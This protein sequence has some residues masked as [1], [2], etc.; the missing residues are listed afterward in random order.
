LKGQL[1]IQYLASFIFFLGLV[2][3]IYFS[4][5]ANLPAFVEEVRKEDV[6]SKAFQL[7]EILI[8]DPGNWTAPVEVKVDVMLIIDVS[9]SMD[10]EAASWG[11]NCKLDCSTFG[12]G[13]CSLNYCSQKNCTDKRCADCDGDGHWADF[14]ESP[15]AI[16][17]AKNASKTFVDQLN[18]TENQD[19]SGIV[20]FNQTD[21][22]KQALVSDKGIVKNSIDQVYANQGANTAIGGGIR[23]ATEHLKNYGRLDAN[24]VQVLL[25]DGRDYPTPSNAEGAAQ[26]AV[27][28]NIKIYTIGLGESGHFNETLLNLIAS[29]TDGKYYHAPSSSDL[30]EIY[31]QIAI[32]MK[33]QPKRIGLSDEKLNKTNLITM[34]K[35]RYLEDLC[36]SFENVQQKLAI[37]EPFSIHIFNISQD[38]GKRNSI[39]ECV[40]PDFPKTIINATIK[41]IVALENTETGQLELAEI[42][43]QM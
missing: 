37:D 27:E 39:M 11:E 35:V 22:L 40:P 8:N 21:Y 38:L 26:E 25:T 7:S 42:I 9:G 14:G 2:I 10:G 17:D 13:L 20:I 29:I 32:E 31:K 18:F 5:S 34:D 33:L 30:E 16:N 41:R 23:N 36:T 6:R 4:Y 28:N 12:T 19:W 1:T 24:L 3:Y 43:V 15:C